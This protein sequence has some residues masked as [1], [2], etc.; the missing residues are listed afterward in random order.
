MDLEDIPPI[1]RKSDHLPHNFPTIWCPVHELRIIL[2]CTRPNCS[3]SRIF[4]CSKCLHDE[5]SHINEH[6]PL[7]ILEDF[8]HY[9]QNTP[10]KETSKPDEKGL[11]AEMDC[12]LNEYTEIAKSEQSLVKKML[13][14][15]GD[16]F[17]DKSEELVSLLETQ[18]ASHNDKFQE[19][20]QKLENE[21]L[22]DDQANAQLPS[23]QEIATEVGRI[24]NSSEKQCEYLKKI[25]R[26]RQAWENASEELK[27]LPKKSFEFYENL[28]S[29]QMKMEPR[30]LNKDQLLETWNKGLTSLIQKVLNQ[31]QIGDQGFIETQY[32]CLNLSRIHDLKLL[33]DEMLRP[34]T[35]L[36]YKP[37]RDEK[38]QPLEIAKCFEQ[39]TC[40]KALALDFSVLSLS[41]EEILQSISSISS[42]NGLKALE[43]NF[44]GV[45]L[46][47]DL[48]PELLKRLKACRALEE[49]SLNLSQNNFGS[50]ED[51]FEGLSNMKHLNDLNLN[52]SGNKLDFSSIESLILL[53]RALKNLENLGLNLSG[54]SLTGPI[55]DKKSYLKLIGS[56]A[57]LIALKKFSLDLGYNDI[58]E[59]GFLELAD[60]L[61]KLPALKHLE[62]ILNNNKLDERCAKKIARYVGKSQLNSLIL[63]AHSNQ[64]NT[65]GVEELFSLLGDG[66]KWSKLE[67][68]LRNVGINKAEA[69]GFIEQYK[70]DNLKIIF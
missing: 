32:V 40:L 58:T 1:T 19:R 63:N 54:Y 59:E 67:M 15:F 33:C 46:G 35:L 52:L 26:K 30:L 43:L 12:N 47:S 42:I 13:N 66:R 2:A 18:L 27:Q 44:A 14:E 53:L 29:Q 60:S 62:L 39:L 4:L 68:N 65:K 38:I 61:K 24:K 37:T 28:V 41:S 69:Y 9:L 36:C 7:L 22:Q 57:D 21:L 23:F 49:L 48:L 70:Q 45:G 20:Y 64:L 56:F 34:E 50:L 11:M 51:F 25:L 3:Y 31:A 6:T 8:I 55:L 5:L 10:F 17:Q 16:I